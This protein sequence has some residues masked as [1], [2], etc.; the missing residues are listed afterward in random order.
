MRSLVLSLFFAVLAMD[1]QPAEAARASTSQAELQRL[2][3][4]WHHCL[5][6][7]YSHQPAGQSRAGNQRNALDECEEQE[8]AYVAASMAAQTDDRGRGRPFASRTSARLGGLD[9]R[10]RAQPDQRLDREPE[11]LSIAKQAPADQR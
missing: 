9:W 6:E 8:N 5:R 3:Q 2:E 4:A 7:A 10:L 1:Q 11:T